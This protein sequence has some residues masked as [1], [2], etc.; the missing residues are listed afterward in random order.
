MTPSS[1]MTMASGLALILSTMPA[2]AASFAPLSSASTFVAQSGKASTVA[3]LGGVRSQHFERRRSQGAFGTSSSGIAIIYTE[4][5]TVSP[6]PTGEVSR[7][8]VILAPTPLANRCVEPRIVEF[9]GSR[10]VRKPRIIFGIQPVC[11]NVSRVAIMG[12]ARE[13][14]RN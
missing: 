6:S 13:G 10:I 5:Q 7:P 8:L 14:A 9:R 4:Y 11:P 2:G 1:S 3:R 12:G